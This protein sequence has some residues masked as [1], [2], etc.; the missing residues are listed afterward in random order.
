MLKPSLQKNSSGTIYLIAEVDERF[1]AFLKA[2]NFSESE[3]NSATGVQTRLQHVAVQNVNHN[4]SSTPIY[5]YIY[6]Y[7]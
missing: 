7:I 1:H 4:I 6:I 3:R 2:W 5:I